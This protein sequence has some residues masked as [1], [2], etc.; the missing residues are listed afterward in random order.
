MGTE[1]N[2]CDKFWGKKKGFSIFIR[3]VF[4]Y[5]VLRLVKSLQL[6]LSDSKTLHLNLVKQPDTIKFFYITDVRNYNTSHVLNF[7]RFFIARQ[8]NLL[9]SMPLASEISMVCVSMPS[10]CFIQSLL[11]NKKVTLQ[12]KSF[13]LNNSFCMN[14]N[15]MIY[16]LDGL[17]EDKKLSH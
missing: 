16:F 3:N 1:G 13:L 11:G 17:K 8:H 6:C 15:N 12:W 2:I 14:I 7:S 10:K 4:F 5:Y 9:Q